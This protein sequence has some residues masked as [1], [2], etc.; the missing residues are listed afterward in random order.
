MHG[1]TTTQMLSVLLSSEANLWCT[2]TPLHRQNRCRV[3]AA[4]VIGIG[5]LPDGSCDCLIID[6]L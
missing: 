5:T 4:W 1:Q 2:A 3:L 6:V